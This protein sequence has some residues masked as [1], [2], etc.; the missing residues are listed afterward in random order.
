M[1]THA[2]PGEAAAMQ[3]EETPIWGGVM[4][5]VNHSGTGNAVIK[6]ASATVNDFEA[7]GHLTA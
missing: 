7:V 1:L 2:G 3:S 5:P 4:K 6:A